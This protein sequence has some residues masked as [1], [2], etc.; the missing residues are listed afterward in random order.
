[1]KQIILWIAYKKKIVCFCCLFWAA[2]NFLSFETAYAQPRCTISRFSTEDGLSD[3]HISAILKDRE[4]FMWFGTWA[5][6]NR[7][8]GHSFV[9]YKSSPGDRST[10]KNN[11]IDRILEDEDGFLWLKTNDR[12]IYR[13]DKKT[14]Q[15]FA[16][17]DIIHEHQKELIAFKEAIIS[18]KGTIWLISENHGVF[19][20]TNANTPKPSCKR[21]AIP[22]VVF[23]HED[24]QRRI[25]I[26]TGKGLKLLIKENGT[27]QSAHVDARLRNLPMSAVAED[28]AHIWLSSDNGA[29]FSYDKLSGLTSHKKI[30]NHKI[31]YLLVSKKR[32]VLYCSTE[33]GEL[34]SIDRDNWQ[35]QVAV[36][37]GK[38]P[39]FTIYEDRA[40]QIWINPDGYGIVRF[41]RNK[42]AFSYYTQQTAPDY[43]RNFRGF[44]IF[45]DKNGLVW[46]VMKGGGFGY[47]DEQTDK[48]SY[49]YNDPNSIEKKFAN[50]VTAVFYDPDGVLWLS[51]YD[52]GLHKVIF[53]ELNFDLKLPVINAHG[54][55]ANDVRGIYKDKGNRLW[56]A[57]KAGML[58]VYKN[59][60][61]QKVRFD[62]IPDKG[63]GMVY[64]ILEDRNHN[65]WLGT[66]GNGLYK[67]EPLNAAQSTYKLTHY[68]EG[69]GDSSLNSKMVFA[70][71]EDHK[72][73][74]WV[75]TNGEG[76]NLISTKGKKVRF[77]NTRNSF[78]KYPRNFYKKIRYLSFDALGRLWIA[79]TN[80]LLIANPN[81]DL[82]A[83]MSFSIYRK[84]PG[85][86]SSLGDNDVQYIYR[87]SRDDMWIATAN[88]GLNKAIAK[89]P[90]KLIFKNFSIKDGLPSDYI[91]SIT[92]D[93][94]HNLWLG[95]QNGLSRFNKIKTFKDYNSFDGLPET[96]FS[97]AA[98]T[99][100]PDG[101]LIFGMVGGI[102]TFQPD[103]LKDAKIQ[104]KI[105]FTNLQINNEDILPGEDKYDINYADRLT[106]KYNQNIVSIDY[107]ILDYRASDN[108]SYQIRLKGFDDV[109]RNNKDRIRATYTNLPPG[110]Y[111][112]EVKCNTVGLYKNIPYKKI[113]IV[114]SPPFW[115]TWWAYLIYVLI[116]GTLFMVIRRT[117]LTVLKLKLQ[118]KHL[119]RLLMEGQKQPEPI[120]EKPALTAQDEVFLQKVIL[121]VEEGMCDPAFNIESM[122]DIS[123]MSRSAFYRKF[124]SLTEMAPIEFVREMRL[125]KAKQLFDSGEQV[126]AEV[127]YQVGFENPNYFGVCFKQYSRYTPSEYIK[128]R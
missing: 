92:E 36:I 126:V 34:L 100:M 69:K 105:A 128:N 88:G 51:T 63:L 4:G 96:T 82:P 50:S 18:A 2:I 89:D 48:M 61:N 28:S 42:Q 25:W 97:E 85:D 29:L 62:N 33:G 58:D 93:N 74:I 79:T 60:Q 8:D 52:R 37:P 49:F 20:I 41:D 120:S 124:K 19:Y 13:F 103:S 54:R 101:K 76:L 65:I 106:L 107:S 118:R 56:V 94:H 123:N 59:G 1:M 78:Y 102:L 23:F 87:D 9:T 66:K 114:I 10:L 127:A 67:A 7:Y 71:A 83:N 14:G 84:I 45:E 113:R 75:G 11:R 72:G 90:E 43:A 24:Q 119:F 5:G 40:G 98:C 12:Q 112:F 99:R 68:T 17:K 115:R 70:L 80:G 27:Y 53:H 32:N 116:A 39:L 21:F 109:W 64:A 117:I 77:I 55:A 26:G 47:Y 31:H 81:A 15:F 3:N 111:L 57:T 30:S 6:I 22:D 125:K 108:R 95:T 35:L 38:T 91:V 46:S 104:G 44:R 122:A 86:I 73:G 110:D 121:F 16:I